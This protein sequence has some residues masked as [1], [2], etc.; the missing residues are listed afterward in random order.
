MYPYDYLDYNDYL[1]HH[2]ILGQ[3]WG[4]RRFQNPDG[5]LTEAGRQRYRSI[6]DKSEKAANTAKKVVGE[7]AKIGGLGLGIG[8]GVAGAALG[9]HLTNTT[10]SMPITLG[11]LGVSAG[12]T[13]PA[14]VAAI[15]AGAAYVNY[16]IKQHNAE[17]KLLND[18]GKKGQAYEVTE[19]DINTLKDLT[20]KALELDRKE[21]KAE[22]NSKLTSKE[23]EEIYDEWQRAEDKVLEY[24]ADLTNKMHNRKVGPYD[25]IIDRKDENWWKDYTK[26]LE[27][28]RS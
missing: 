16:K 12:L 9:A 10:L 20:K 4:V 11:A 24:A 27:E 18:L 8:S 21:Q 15:S 25:D 3:K 19:N 26:I 6:A 13:A 23:F 5:T 22:N 1:M 28:A 2:G 7:S 17:K 14:T